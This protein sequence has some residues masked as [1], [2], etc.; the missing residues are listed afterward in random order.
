MTVRELRILPPLAISRLGAAPR[1]MDNYDVEVDPERPLGGRRL[2]PARTF[3]VD[4]ESGEITSDSVPEGLRFTE[5]GEVRPVAPFL[6]VWALTEEE[7]RPLTSELLSQAGAT[8][9]DVR[10]RVHLGNHKI[11]RRTGDVADKIDAEVEVSG[12]ERQAV[13]GTCPNFWDGKRLPLG[14]VQYV[15]PT[16]EFPEIRLRYTPAGGFVYGSSKKSPDRPDEPDLN[17]KEVLYDA[18]KGE[19][20]GYEE[21]EGPQTTVPGQI[22]AGHENGNKQVSAGYLD[23]ECDG[24]VRVELRVGGELLS[25]HAHLGAG[26]PAYAPDR[27]PIR[28][29]ADELE[30]AIEGPGFDPGDVTAAEIAEV[31]EIVR[32][33]FETI[34]LMNTEVMN[35]NTVD[36]QVDVASTMVRQDTADTGRFF[37][38]IMATSLV[39]MVALENLHQNLL[40]ALRSGTAPWFAEVLRDYDKIGDLSNHGRR[41]MPA[42]MRGAD[43]RHLALTRRQVNIIR[44]VA[45]RAVAAGDNRPSGQEEER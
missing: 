41:K 10:W 11:Y 20:L 40:V 34:G 30:Q 8:P 39:D 2:T 32:R 29:V 18:N 25:A 45:S 15:R 1:P 23:D 24:L 13:E 35:G 27:F 9:A 43:G 28:T 37:E 6:E 17:V 16:P 33:A 44:A 38:P 12:H 14:H 22:F 36:G 4:P 31:E 21:G 5:E 19:W 7:L 26:P 42:M 3:E